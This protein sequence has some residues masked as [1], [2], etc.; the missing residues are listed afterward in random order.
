[1]LG[2]MEE[3]EINHSGV[4]KE[5]KEEK[6]EI[7]EEMVKKASMKESGLAQGQNLKASPDQ[8]LGP[9]EGG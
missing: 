3:A 4:A 1:M 7:H 8:D 9:W 5:K 6:L 2:K